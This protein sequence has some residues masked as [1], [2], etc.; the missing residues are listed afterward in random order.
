MDTLEK[1][2]LNANP[3]DG[4]QWL[5]LLP[6]LEKQACLK[7]QL[8]NPRRIPDLSWHY[9]FEAEH[10]TYGEVVVKLGK[11]T[12]SLSREASVLESFSKTQVMVKLLDQD[13]SL[14]ALLLNKITPGQRLNALPMSQKIDH[15]GQVIQKLHQNPIKNNLQIPSVQ[16]WL[17]CLENMSTSFFSTALR[18]QY[19][20]CLSKIK[21]ENIQLCH[22]DLHCDNLLKSEKGYAAIDP[23]GI[24]ASRAFECAAFDLLSND[25]LNTEGAQEIAQSRI[26]ALSIATQ[27]DKKDLTRWIFIRCLLSA[28]WFI[29]DGG[30]PRNMIQTAQLICP[31]V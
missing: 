14:G 19:Q 16:E 15:F 31:L 1:N 9:L 27:C 23:K 7:W 17:S 24:L 8:S 6:Q 28:Q 5:A 20:N 10:A 25:E 30:N 21:T 13:I 4:H 11:D 22:G 29:Q 18:A 2:I 26:E 3:T 12:A